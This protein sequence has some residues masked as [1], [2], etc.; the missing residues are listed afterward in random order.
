M[1]KIIEA[2]DLDLDVTVHLNQI[3]YVEAINNDVFVTTNAGVYKI[4]EKLY[5]FDELYRADGFIRVSKSFII[6]I[7]RVVKASSQINSRI[8]LTMISNE[9]IYVTRGYLKEFK[10][11]IRSV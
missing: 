3:N 6:N 5:L 10:A 1:D 9:T 8:K 7:R 11:F 4:K 2:K